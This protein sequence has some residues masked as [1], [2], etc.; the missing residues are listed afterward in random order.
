MAPDAGSAGRAMSAAGP[1]LR[2]FADHDSL[3]VALADRVARRLRAGLASRGAASLL[4]P[5]GR[6]P[7]PFLEHLACSELDWQRVT[8]GLTD[9]RWVPVADA[10]SNER[11]LR[12]H[13]LRDAA[14]QAR[15][16]GLVNEA[17]DAALGA[18]RAWNNLESLP[19]PF[20][21]VV[22]GM[23]E[24][25]HFASLFPD[26]EASRAGLDV[27]APPACIAVRAPVAPVQRVS[28]NLAA[29]LQAR[30][31]FLLVTGERKWALLEQQLHAARAQGLPVHALLAQRRAPLT[32][33]WSP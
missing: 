15:V 1:L 6:T 27:D 21:A 31:L 22:L 13:L 16:Q 12:T 17:A 20:D 26:D 4:V 32:V 29:L 30:E 33:F 11:L 25:G 14:T 2:R 5:G 10:A 9:E 24:D 3:V 19:R 23:G 8:V 7:A 18:L 28:L